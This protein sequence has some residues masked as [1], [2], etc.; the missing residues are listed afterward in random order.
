MKGKYRFL[1][2][3]AV[4]TLISCALGGV[5]GLISPRFGFPFYFGFFSGFTLGGLT[6]LFVLAAKMGSERTKRE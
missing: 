3:F 4:W 1:V 6:A 2:F 5:C